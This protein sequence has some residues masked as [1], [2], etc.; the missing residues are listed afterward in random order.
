VDAPDFPQFQTIDFRGVTEMTAN[1]AKLTHR[2][3]PSD[4]AE[5]YIQDGYV[6]VDDLVTAIERGRIID[7]ATGFLDGTYP[8]SN[9]PDDGDV[10][11]VHFPHW[12]SPV[13]R[14]AVVH[15][16]IAEVVGTIAGAHLPGWDGRTKC[17]QSMLFF[18]PPGLQGQAWHQDERFIPTRDRS[19]VGAWIALDD[20]TIDNGCIWVL[21]GSHRTGMIHPTRPHSRVEE[22]DHSDEAYGFDESAAVPVEV[23]A[24]SVV[25]FNGYLLH[26]SFRNRSNGTRMALVN[27]YMNAW[28]LLPW[29]VGEGIEVGTADTRT[30]VPVT[31]DDPYVDKGVD[32]SPGVTFVRPRVTPES[33]QFR[34]PSADAFNRSTDTDVLPDEG[35]PV[36][37]IDTGLTIAV[38]VADVWKVLIDFDRYSDWN[39]HIAVTQVAGATESTMTVTTQPTDR[40]RSSTYD[41]DV[42]SVEAPHRLEW[43]VGLPDREK[44]SVRLVWTLTQTPD[45]TDLH[46]YA[47]FHGANERTSFEITE[48]G[49]RQDLERSTSALKAACENRGHLD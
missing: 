11:A 25:F 45:G 33:S 22:F 6:V 40:H 18:K 41:V 23:R 42:V 5:Q 29:Q 19:L 24:G 14:D 47:T 36:L 38:P 12:V 34:D 30:I 2:T 37:R 49:F 31:G 28:S 20:A 35:E 3:L 44:F 48:A 46:H 17:M 21:P 7:D 9:M 39:P 4:I 27:H 1:D 15:P 26:R 10:L 43:R 13:A 32:E 16:G 8:V